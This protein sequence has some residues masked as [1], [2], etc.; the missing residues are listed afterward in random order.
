MIPCIYI[1]ATQP[2]KR[3]LDHLL[4]QISFFTLKFKF[5]LQVKVRI[6]SI[7]LICII[8][9][10]THKDFFQIFPR[11]LVILELLKNLLHLKQLWIP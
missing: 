6:F 5:L 11:M 2:Y 10:A 9:A 3:G 8:F 7:D 4:L 1:G